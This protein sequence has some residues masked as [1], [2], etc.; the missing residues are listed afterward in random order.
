MEKKVLEQL[1]YDFYGELLSD[2][3]KSVMEYYYNDD[4]SLTEIGDLLGMTRQ[5][6]YDACKRARHL[7]REYEEKLGLVQRYLKS[8][9]LLQ[10]ITGEITRLTEDARI[11]QDPELLGEIEALKSGIDEIIEG[12]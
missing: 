12:Y 4:Y 6:V 9:S 10:D 2:R 5:G 3:Q 8:R 1:W 11:V 7:M